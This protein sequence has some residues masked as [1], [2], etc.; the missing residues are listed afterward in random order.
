MN[1]GYIKE[2]AADILVPIAVLCVGLAALFAMA[3]TLLYGAIATLQQAECE[4]RGRR[5]SLP[6]E[7]TALSGCMVKLG[8]QWLPWEMVVAVERDG[9]VVFIPKPVLGASK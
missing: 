6:V 7:Y 1:W 4:D 3:V 8:R 2:T 5:M 9:Q